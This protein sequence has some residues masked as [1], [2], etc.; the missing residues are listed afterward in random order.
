MLKREGIAAERIYLFVADA[1]EAAVYATAEVG[2]IIVGVPGINR[3]REFIHEFFDVGK[4]VVCID[5]DVSAIRRPFQKNVALGTLLDQMFLLMA[6]EECRLAGIYPC[7]HGLQ[8]KD[9]MIKGQLFIIGC[10]HLMRN[11][12]GTVYPHPT[13]ED[14]HRSLV[15]GPVLRFEGLG[16]TTRYAKEPGG[17]QSYR[18]AE[19]QEQ[20]MI[21]LTE[22]WP[23]K[24][25]LRRKKNGYVD[26]RIKRR[27]ER[28][29]QQP[30]S[31]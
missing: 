20:E 1:S 15:A 16:P 4:P 2:H 21:A 27:V 3:Q 26:A 25:I 31:E 24:A 11:W 30:F 13:S 17:L 12:K 14:Y 7:D 19:I 10:F 29:V 23:D 8:L 9:R 18:T 5:D 6:K 28:I 22:Q